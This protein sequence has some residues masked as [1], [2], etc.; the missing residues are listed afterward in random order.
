[1]RTD[2][3]NLD[4]KLLREIWDHASGLCECYPL[5]KLSPASEKK[6]DIGFFLSHRMQT[7]ATHAQRRASLAPRA[8]MLVTGRQAALTDSKEQTGICNYSGDSL[9]GGGVAVLVDA[10][11]RLPG[12]VFLSSG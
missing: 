11:V 7:A 9:G 10:L 6:T 3:E 4:R 12:T 1:M 5:F 8:P 2:T